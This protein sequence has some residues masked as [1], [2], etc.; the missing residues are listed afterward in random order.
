MAV[1]EDGSVKPTEYELEVLI[2]QQFAKKAE[3][4]KLEKC[5]ICTYFGTKE[6]MNYH[7]LGM[8]H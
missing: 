4:E 3:D 1:S 6:Q 2:D 5:G 8:G 7:K